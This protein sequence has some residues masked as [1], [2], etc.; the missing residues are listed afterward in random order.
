MNAPLLARPAPLLPALLTCLL[1]ACVWVPMQPEA[2]QVTVYPRGQSMAACKP[3]GELATS[4]TARVGPYE[5]N[6]LSVRDELETL[7][8]NEALSLH[9]DA[10]QPLEEPANGRQRWQAYRCAAASR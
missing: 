2:A 7:A 5:R 4:V 9:A 8:R 10:V 1:A 6:R 3:L